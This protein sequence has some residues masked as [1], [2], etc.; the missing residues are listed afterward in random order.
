MP[1]DKD[2]EKY[3]RIVERLRAGKPVSKEEMKHFTSYSQD[4]DEVK[5]AKIRTKLSSSEGLKNLTDQ[6]VS[7]Y[8]DEAKKALTSD[9]YKD[10]TLELAKD[11]QEGRTSD[12]VAQGLNTVLAGIDIGTSINQINQGKKL[13]A[14]NVRPNRPLAPGRDPY[15]A[16]ALNQAQLGTMDQSKALAPAQLQILDQYLS[17]LN[18]AKTAS[19]G[20]AGI[21]G[22]LGQEAANRRNRASLDLVPLADQI[23]AREQGRYGDLLQMR[24]N[25]T[26]NNFQNQAQFYPSDLAQYNLTNQMAGNLSSQGRVNLRNSLANAG[27]SIPDIVA[28]LR[29][30]QQY[31]KLYNQMSANHGDVAA[32]AA[33]YANKSLNDKYSNINSDD[34]LYNQAY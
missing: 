31:N 3:L 1:R 16:Q 10:Q 32:N 25:E 17:D 14:G 11:A 27:Q 2:L 30:D 5:L 8:I 34:N 33:V 28:K 7:D 15:L 22:A 24:Q 4:V 23:K 12:K 6:D 9:T 26:Q 18:N 20:Q 19:A 29:S 13:A 21:Y